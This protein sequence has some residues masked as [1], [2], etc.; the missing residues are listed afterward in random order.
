GIRGVLEPSFGRDA[1][2]ALGE[3]RRWPLGG[4]GQRVL[5]LYVPT[6]GSRAT[7]AARG[8]ARADAAAR[9]RVAAGTAGNARAARIG[10]RSSFRRVLRPVTTSRITTGRGE[11]ARAEK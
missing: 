7:R 8:V 3:A 5:D 9:T 11:Q 4:I 2:A 1:A 10:G 6:A